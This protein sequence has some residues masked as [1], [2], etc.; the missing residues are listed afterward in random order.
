M[1]TNSHIPVSDRVERLFMMYRLFV[2]IK[3]LPLLYFKNLPLTH[4]DS[5]LHLPISLLMFTHWL[6]HIRSEYAQ[7]G[8]NYALN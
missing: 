2:K 6:I 7:N 5:F 3:Y 4:F 8:L 1:F